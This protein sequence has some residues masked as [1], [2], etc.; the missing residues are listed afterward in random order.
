MN[1]QWPLE[2]KRPLADVLISNRADA[3]ALNAQLAAALSP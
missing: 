2:R 3:A 1:A